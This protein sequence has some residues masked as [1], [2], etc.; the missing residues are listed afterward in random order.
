MRQCPNVTPEGCQTCA[1]CSFAGREPSPY[2][3]RRAA[4]KIKADN[5]PEEDD[6]HA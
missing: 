4:R 2:L 6:E 3:L 5:G 1:H